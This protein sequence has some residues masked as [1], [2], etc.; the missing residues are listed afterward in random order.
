MTL[1]YSGSKREIF[2]WRPELDI[3]ARFVAVA[4]LAGATLP[5]SAIIRIGA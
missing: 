4:P 5:N 3:E 2:D 1:I